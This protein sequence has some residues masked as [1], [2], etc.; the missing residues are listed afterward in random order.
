[1]EIIVR[2]VQSL[3]HFGVRPPQQRGLDLLLALAIQVSRPEGNI[4]GLV[5]YGKRSVEYAMHGS[6]CESRLTHR[7]PYPCHSKLQI[8][9]VQANGV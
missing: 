3:V 4:R 8:L 5:V 1:M 2:W 7:P 6:R 9:L